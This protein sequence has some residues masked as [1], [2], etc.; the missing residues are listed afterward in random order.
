[1]E[2]AQTI[3]IIPARF[4]SSR[5]PGKPLALINGK[6]LIQRTYEKALK[7]NSLDFLCVATD[8]ARIYDHVQNF[9][10]NA[11]MT[12]SDCPTGTERVAEAVEKE[13]P[14]A[15]IVVNIQGDE[16]CLNPDVI[17]KLV[18]QMKCSK[19]AFLTT[20]VALLTDPKDINS[21]SVVKCV[22]T[23]EGKAL[24]FSR[25]PIPFYQKSVRHFSYYRHL[26]LYCYRKETLLQY[27]GFPKTPLQ[28]IE[29]LEQLKI[30][31]KGFSIY[32]TVVEDDGIGVDTPEDLKRV[33]E[34]LCKEDISLLPA[35]SS[36][37]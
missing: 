10:G 1:M 30:L 36:L 26:G 34:K 22:F 11:V 8:D 3:G 16:P 23:P 2:I 27:T 15:K 9:E 37:L 28:E 13:F 6:S 19:N 32:V 21:P 31:E 25:A 18:N 29:D 4:G 33:E 20:P 14:E 24:Y 5:F 7:S 35:A 12:S 17:D